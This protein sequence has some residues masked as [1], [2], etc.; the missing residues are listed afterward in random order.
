MKNG[1][2][3]LRDTNSQIQQ[4]LLMYP[5]IDFMTDAMVRIEMAFRVP[6]QKLNADVRSRTFEPEAGEDAS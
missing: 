2:S 3:G 6:V 4:Q 5:S 1:L